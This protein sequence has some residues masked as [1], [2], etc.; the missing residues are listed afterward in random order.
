MAWV[1]LFI[2]SLCEVGWLI[3]L[4]YS[5]G[6]SRLPSILV[7]VGFMGASVGCLGLA[8]KTIP[9]GTAY[10]AWTGASIAVATLFGIYLF[11]E[12]TTATRLVSIG[13]IVLGIVGLRLESG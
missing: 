2:G 1:I 4:K 11:D 6:L 10:A 8:V 12:P 13:L 7:T 3:A 9:M 5:E